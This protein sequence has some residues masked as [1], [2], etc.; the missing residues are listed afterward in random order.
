MT[1]VPQTV[2]C[3]N[4]NCLPVKPGAMG[5]PVPGYEIDVSS[6]VSFIFLVHRYMDYHLSNYVVPSRIV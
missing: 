4:F 2:I 5:K 3:A 6:L 1:A